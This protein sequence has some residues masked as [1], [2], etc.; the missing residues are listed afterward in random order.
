MKQKLI[1]IQCPN[2][3]TEYLP[4]EIFLPFN[5]FNRP[6]FIKKD[7]NGKIVNQ[8]DGEINLCE[9]Y[10]CDTCNKKFEITSSI[11]FDT[12]LVDEEDFSQDF[13]VKI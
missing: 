12:K 3:G 4:A 6:F 1:I 13:C 8:I 11:V 5:Y 9:S 2:C 10:I 7:E